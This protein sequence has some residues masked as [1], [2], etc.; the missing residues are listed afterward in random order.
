[1]PAQGDKLTI[2]DGINP[3]V[4]FEFS[5]PAG[6]VAIYSIKVVLIA[7]DGYAM[8]RNLEAAINAVAAGLMIKAQAQFVENVL[9]FTTGGPVIDLELAVQIDSVSVANTAT[10]LGG[11]PWTPRIITQH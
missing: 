2:A 4:A 5:L 9:R 1:M 3:A 10:N 8:I 6:N 11:W 7:G